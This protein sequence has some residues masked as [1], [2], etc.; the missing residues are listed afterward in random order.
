M[1]GMNTRSAHKYILFAIAQR[2][3]N[4]H[5]QWPSNQ[6]DVEFTAPAYGLVFVP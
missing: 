3:R 1:L 6:C 4:W 2:Q 5:D